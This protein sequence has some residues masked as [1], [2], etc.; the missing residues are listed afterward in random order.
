MF[1]IIQIA[2]TGLQLDPQQRQEMID[3]L[4]RKTPFHLNLT[5]SVN[6]IVSTCT[7]FDLN[8][9][10]IFVKNAIPICSENPRPKIVQLL[11]LNLFALHWN[12]I[13]YY[14]DMSIYFI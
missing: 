9:M 7:I 14:T 5:H 3:W 10:K 11:A 12:T 1:N 8:I 13:P 6:T 2:L 4:K